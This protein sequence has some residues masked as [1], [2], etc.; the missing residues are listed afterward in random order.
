MA[1]P[2]TINELL[3]D[4]LAVRGNWAVACLNPQI[5]WPTDVHKVTFRGHLIF[6]LPQVG[7]FFPGVAVM[8]QGDLK[9]FADAQK[10]LMKFLSALSWMKEGGIIISHWF[11]GSLPSPMAGFGRN[12]GYPILTESF[13]LFDLPEPTEQKAQWA[14][15]F[16]REG[17]SIS[18]GLPAYSF[19]SF[20][21]IINL[22]A[23]NGREQ[24][25]WINQSVEKAAK[26]SFRTHNA[27]QRLKDLQ[28]RG[29]NLGEYLYESGRC[30]VAHAGQGE[31][32]DPEDPADLDRLR[33]DLPLMQ[34][35]AAYAIETVFG[36]RSRTSIYREHLYE[37]EGF[38]SILDNRIVERLKAGE[39]IPV[40]QITFPNITVGL[41]GQSDYPGLAN[42][43]V[44]TKDCKDGQVL[45]ECK[46]ASGCTELLLQL[47]FPG[48]RL[49]ID[50]IDGL[51][52]HDD[53]TVEAAEHALSVAQFRKDYF[54]NGRLIVDVAD[55]KKRLGH[56]DAFLPHN[57]DMNATNRDFDS[58]I[59]KLR[60]LIEQRR[61][62]RQGGQ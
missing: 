19:L 25:E 15:G 12:Q 22:F 55:T 8:I 45:L 17:Q 5:A 37:L 53:N 9:A 56:C 52:S 59:A 62:A 10:L 31:T 36:I 54:G 26:P 49:L 35:L 60:E 61:L 57:V 43:T 39:T 40:D 21:K 23:A 11:G 27:R 50:T 32:V 4:E 58:L 20:Y 33:A 41:L 2:K 34:A 42:L 28:Q 7:D 6:L 18:S 38:K 24:K 48:E 14:L 51:A 30:A 46:S 29:T 3:K 16:F 47:D 44:N 1:Q 13:E